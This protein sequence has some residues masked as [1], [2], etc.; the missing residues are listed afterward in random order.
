MALTEPAGGVGVAG[1]GT[2][3]DYG[4]HV[5][6][7]DIPLYVP[8]KAREAINTLALNTLRLALNVVA[9]EVSQAAGEFSDTGHL[10]QSFTADPATST[11]G[12]EII[13]ASAS[14]G[15]FGGR[16]FSSLPHA[17][18]MEEGRRPGAPISRDGIDAIGLWA[19]RK[20]GLSK[21]ESDGAK[22]AIVYNIVAQGISGKGYFEQGVNRARP[23]VEGMF[24]ALGAAVA[25]ELVS[26]KKTGPARDSRGKFM[27]RT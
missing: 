11:G 10:A 18:V 3:P 14:S 16:V 19:Q 6:L 4:I 24:Q 15:D 12:I 8:T 26:T 9:G 27:K 2:R 21:E 20:L 7:P 5:I 1:M 17:I 22:W 25:A 23:T 13:G